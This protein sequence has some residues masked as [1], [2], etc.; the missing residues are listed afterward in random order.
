MA[1]V[2]VKEFAKRQKFIFYI[3][4]CF[5]WV[6]SLAHEDKNC[7]LVVRMELKNYICF[8][9]FRAGICDPQILALNPLWGNFRFLHYAL[10]N[11]R[12]IN[13]EF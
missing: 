11:L 5:C 1:L 3:D 9:G 12:F 7:A 4:H 2:H 13:N 6:E 10:P 8:G